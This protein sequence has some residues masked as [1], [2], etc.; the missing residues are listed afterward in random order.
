MSGISKLIRLCVVDLKRRRIENEIE[1]TNDGSELK[2][3]YYSVKVDADKFVSA[4]SL[5]EKKMKSLKLKLDDAVSEKE[6]M[7]KMLFSSDVDSKQIS[8]IQESLK[9]VSEHVD[10]LETEELELLEKFEKYK[11]F[12]DKLQEKLALIKEKYQEVLGNYKKIKEKG[13]EKILE[14]DIEREELLPQIDEDQLEIYGN[15]AKRKDGIAMAEVIGTLCSGCNETI[16]KSLDQR[17][18]EEP[19]EIHYCNNCGRIIYRIKVES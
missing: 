19:D 6:K 17:L 14:I 16:S 10:K 13:E 3:Q 1:N 12:R 8:N 15:L 7:E 5:I 2:A 18:S 4:V 9:K 11:S